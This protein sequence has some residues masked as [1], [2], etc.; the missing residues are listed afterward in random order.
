[1]HEGTEAFNSV[2]GEDGT[3]LVNAKNA[4]EYGII[5]A[6]SHCEMMLRNNVGEWENWYK[7]NKNRYNIQG[8]SSSAAW[9]YTINKTAI[10]AYWEERVASNKD[11]ENIFSM[12]LRGVHD[13]GPALAKLDTFIS[14]KGQDNALGSSITVKGTSQEA[15]KVALM[16][17]VIHEQ[18]K[19]I[20]KYYGSEDGA[21]QVFIPYKEMNEYYNY[22]NRDLADWLTEEASDIILMWAND[23]Y[24][25]FRQT[26]NE[27]ERAE[28]RRN[29]V[30]YHNSYW[31][32]PKSYLWLNSASIAQMNAEMHKAYNTGANT[33]WILNVGDIK[34]GEI[35][36]E[37]FMRMAWD[38]ESADDSRIKEA[39]AAQVG[40]DFNVSQR[41]AEE[42]ADCLDRYYQYNATKR[43]EFYGKGYDFSVSGN[44]DEGMLWVNQWNDLV[45]R[46]EKIYDSLDEN[47]RDAFYEQI[48][49]AVRSSRDVAEEYIYCLK[50]EQAV[51]QGRYGS[52]IVY[53]KLGTEAIS[54]IEEG[55]NKF[56]SL[57]EG[58]W[59][60]VINYTHRARYRYGD[61]TEWSGDYQPDQGILL[62]TEGDYKT[63]EPGEGVGAA[64]E[65]ASKAGSGKLYFSS[66]NKERGEAHYFDVFGKGTGAAAWT[67]TAPD[68]IS[69]TKKSGSVY[70]EER[71]IATVDW[72]KLTESAE[73]EIKVY[74]GTEVS[75][76]PVAVFTIKADCVQSQLG[77]ERKGY[78]EAGGYVMIEA[79]HWSENVAGTDGTKWQRIQSLGQRG[80]SIRITTKEEN[81]VN[82]QQGDVAAYNEFANGTLGEADKEKVGHVAYDVYFE[83]AGTYKFIAY[84][85]P[86][87]DESTTNCRTAVV[88]NGESSDKAWIRGTATTLSETWSGNILHMIE[89][90]QSAQ[91][92]VNKGWNRIELY[93]MSPSQAFDRFLIVTDASAAPSLSKMEIG[94]PVS[95]NNIVA[96]GELK[97]FQKQ[98]IG[99]LPEK[100][101]Q[102]GGITVKSSGREV[103]IG[104][105]L[106][107]ETQQSGE[108]EY[109]LEWSSSDESVAKVKDGA[110]TGLAIGS[111]KITVKLKKDGTVADSDTV[112]VKVFGKAGK[113][114]A[115]FSLDGTESGYRGAGALAALYSKDGK[116]PVFPYKE[117]GGKSGLYFDS[118]RWLEVTKEDGSPLMKG[119]SEFTISYDSYTA[120]TSNANY[121]FFATNTHEE[122]KATA[123]NSATYPRFGM[124]D[125]TGTLRVLNGG[126]T[127]DATAA[128]KKWKHVDVVYSGKDVTTYIDGKKQISNEAFDG[129]KKILSADKSY[130]WIGKGPFTPVNT[131]IYSGYL[132]GYRIYDYALLTDEIK[133]EIAEQEEHTHEAGA[134]W[135]SD[136]KTHWHECSICGAHLDESA[137]KEDEGTVTKQANGTEE[138]EETYKCSVCGSVMRTEKIPV[139]GEAVTQNPVTQSPATLSLNKSKVTLYTGKALNSATIK[140]TVTGTSDVVVWRSSNPKAATVKA[141]KITATGKGTATITAAVGGVSHSV[142]V[143]VKNPSIT[144]KR[145]K[146]RV[147]KVSLRVKKKMTLTVRTNPKKAGAKLES[148][149]KKNK[150]I[151]TAKLKNGKLTVKAKKKG[152]VVLVIK[153][154]KGKKKITVIVK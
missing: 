35:S 144:V 141:G 45:D 56:W 60:H 31:G 93:R 30:Y 110:V 121:T 126:G 118:T 40:R 138:G 70:T 125:Y 132:A 44:G 97:E 91:I 50:N 34:P 7:A 122:G 64:C 145:G 119:L 23:N 114:I 153:S 79:E 131:Q 6:S 25:Y 58:K 49:H 57:N 73:G 87:L 115:D 8:A 18:R 66:L 101:G 134:E 29:G 117:I 28:G 120:S 86:T 96:D 105:S 14:N 36:A 84:R 4:A 3:E 140:A 10:L 124:V 104:E 54:R 42:I 152:R 62:K 72:S 63:A 143:T 21:P 80:D 71:V 127:F 59:D 150:K 55:Q 98:R 39:L 133:K 139:S 135:K 106:I 142:K 102:S 16:K 147:S 12:G 113:L 48:L 89:S 130:V 22:N 77:G 149:S 26:P 47:A 136:E 43:A 112:V 148:L 2:T 78:Q 51:A 107:L 19:I 116:A 123:A 151:M 27:K 154:G 82:T 69:L 85:L 61:G 74:N 83:K 99:E 52:S 17:D 38:I 111:A 67:A 53:R 15:K 65:N 100:L 24:G 128:G 81:K 46:L 129:I 95:P 37:Y 146:K 9:D 108:G 11:F 5:M 33:Y 92:T 68:W 13:G 88:V 20:E 109:E 75:G 1:M 137:H 76:E 103:R 41:D 94:M 90:M 32:W